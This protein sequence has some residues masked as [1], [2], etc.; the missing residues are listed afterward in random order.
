V[1][2]VLAYVKEIGGL[3]EI[4]KRNAKKAEILYGA[5]ARSRSSSAR[6]SNARAAP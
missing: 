1:R 6:P 2:N 4:E 3:A 5:I